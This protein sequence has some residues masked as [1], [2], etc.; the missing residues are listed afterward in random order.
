LKKL[1]FLICYQQREQA[2][3]PEGE[4]SDGLFQSVPTILLLP[5]T[6]KLSTDSSPRIA[7]DANSSRFFFYFGKF[8]I[9]AMCF[10]WRPRYAQ[11]GRATFALDCVASHHV[12]LRK[13]LIPNRNSL[14]TGWLVRD[15][16]NR[17]RLSYRIRERST[18]FLDQLIGHPVCGCGSLS[19]MG[20][21]SLERAMGMTLVGI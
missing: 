21:L 16:A 1:Y 11:R 18:L 10:I 4:W 15:V 2:N 20:Y 14:R 19:V 13:N 9:C 3:E 6:G 12:V 17:R 5:L 8:R 7:I